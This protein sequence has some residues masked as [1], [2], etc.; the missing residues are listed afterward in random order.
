MGTASSKIPISSINCRKLN[1]RRKGMQNVILSPR[2]C[3]SIFQRTHGQ[4]S[5]QDL[6][7]LKNY[8]GSSSNKST[9]KIKSRKAESEI[10]RKLERKT[11]LSNSLQSETENYLMNLMTTLEHHGQD[12][13]LILVILRRLEHLYA[14][15]L[16]VADKSFFFNRLKNFLMSLFLSKLTPKT[17]RKSPS[18]LPS[19]Q[20]QERAH[21]FSLFLATKLWQHF[22]GHNFVNKKIKAKLKKV[23]S[24]N[25]NVYY[26]CKFTNRISHVKFDNEIYQAIFT[27]EKL[28]SG[29]KKRLEQIL[30]ALDHLQHQS[31]GKISDFFI[32]ST[33]ELKKLK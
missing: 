11:H 21:K 22:Y 8:L 17:L 24:L 16:K 32:K 7:N 19:V 26:T 28:S 15:N 30:K 5:E 18:K 10:I 12:S 29:A 4:C 14:D 13:K 3:A 31:D 6:K 2:L 9:T 20:G 33:A 25:T 23:L 1:L 27:N